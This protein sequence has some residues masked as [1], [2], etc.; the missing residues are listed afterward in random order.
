MNNTNTPAVCS[1]FVPYAGDDSL[2]GRMWQ[3]H[4]GIVVVTSERTAGGLY[5]VQ[6]ADGRRHAIR[7]EFIRAALAESEIV[8]EPVEV[9]AARSAAAAADLIDDE[10]RA[11]LARWAK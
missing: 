11:A 4:D 6:R 10:T 5:F 8:R 9:I 1:S 7:P 3:S 2:P